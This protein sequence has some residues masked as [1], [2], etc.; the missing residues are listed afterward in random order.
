MNKYAILC[1]EEQTKKALELGA[2][3]EYYIQGDSKVIYNKEEGY[4]KIP[5]AEEMIGWL[6]EQESIYEV[7]IA[8]IGNITW[9][10][11]IW[12]NELFPV[13]NHNM[14]NTRKEAT[15]AAIDYAL[16]YLKQHKQ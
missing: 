9:S 8:S 13:D 6:E 2:P 5:T 11:C 3:L 12:D 7:D 14:Y 10:F 15:L 1:T 16:Y 4:I